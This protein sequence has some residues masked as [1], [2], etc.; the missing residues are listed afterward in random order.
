MDTSIAIGGWLLSAYILGM[1]SSG[2]LIAERAGADIRSL[3]TGNPGAANVYRE[4]GRRHGAAVFLLDV[5]K[6]LAV[7][8]P[9]LILEADPEIRYA[10]TLAVIAGHL[11][12]GRIWRDG[13]TG[14]AV[15]MGAAIGLAPVGAVA[16]TIAGVFTLVVTRNP[17]FAGATAFLATA[18]TSALL[19]PHE[20]H[21]AFGIVGIGV[22]IGV[23]AK[24]QYRHE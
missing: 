20:T 21:L 6:G 3:G 8:L 5:A 18:A 2:D 13:G 12:P 9:L 19:V 23:K 16:G 10:S 14:M 1:A 24:V 7:T 15:A 4:V 22:I 11:F 17:G